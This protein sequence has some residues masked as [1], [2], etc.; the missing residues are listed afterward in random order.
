[1]NQ[2]FQLMNSCGPCWARHALPLG[3]VAAGWFAALAM[4]LAVAAAASASADEPQSDVPAAL[5]WARDEAV[6]FGQLAEASRDTQE[7]LAELE[8]QHKTLR[9]AADEANKLRDSGKTPEERVAAQ[10]KYLALRNELDSLQQ[11]ILLARSQVELK[12]AAAIAQQRVAALEELIARGGEIRSDPRSIRLFRTYTGTAPMLSVRCDPRG[13]HVLAG[14]L[15][16]D[17]L[18]WDL[19]SGEATPLKGHRSWV[20]QFVFGPEAMISAGYDGRVLWWDARAPRPAPQREIVAHQGWVRAVSLSPDARLLATGG[21]DRMVR[22]W[23]ADDGRLV[24]ELA[25]HDANV[26]VVAWDP[27]GKQLVSGDLNGVVKHWDIDTGEQ[28][29]EFDARLLYKPTGNGLIG[30]IRD[31]VFSPD[32]KSLAVCGV[33]KVR[34]ALNLVGT[35][36]IVLFDWETGQQRQPCE[37][38]GPGMCWA[39]RFD[40]TGSY[41]VGTGGRTSGELW[42]FHPDKPE[43]FFVHSLPDIGFDLDFH[44]DGLRL[45]VALSDGTVRLYDLCPREDAATSDEPAADGAAVAADADADA[46]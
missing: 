28:L 5:R 29:R 2:R 8:A 9:T 42:F 22:L 33:S 44:P 40:P 14:A 38:K 4:A 6:R 35:P 25:G 11:Q 3:R 20:R 36:T 45:A 32:G 1:M 43:P 7:E 10:Q 23:S 17:L 46:Q 16:Q 15:T 18:R 21:N 37:A 30:G 34:D 39:V 27:T 24:K 13:G 12:E 31:L 41:L 26:Y 19:V